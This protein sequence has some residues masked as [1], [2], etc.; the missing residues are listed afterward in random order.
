M[1]SAGRG[2]IPPKSVPPLCVWFLFDSSIA[3]NASIYMLTACRGLCPLTP[4]GLCRNF[5]QV[6]SPN[7]TLRKLSNSPFSKLFDGL[8][9]VAPGRGTVMLDTCCGVRPMDYRR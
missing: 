3:S 6:G 1:A 8:R 2:E 9:R 4:D 5:P 7:Y